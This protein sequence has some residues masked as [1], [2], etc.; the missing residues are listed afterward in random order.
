VNWPPK[1]RAAA[2]VV[3]GQSILDPSRKLHKQLDKKIAG[4][5]HAW[6]TAFDPWSDEQEEYADDVLAAA[7]RIGAGDKRKVAAISHVSTKLDDVIRAERVFNGFQRRKQT[8]MADE[9]RAALEGLATRPV[10][11]TDGRA[12]ER[13]EGGRE[14]FRQA[15]EQHYE[16][17]EGDE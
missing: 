13:T 4:C 3:F 11:T 9:I 10:G 2:V 16:S 1:T 8:D 12:Y 7:I 17:L 6:H 14:I 5:L 15:I